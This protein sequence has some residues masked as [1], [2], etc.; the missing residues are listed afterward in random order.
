MQPPIQ[1]GYPFIHN[2]QPWSHCG[3]AF[4]LQAE[5]QEFESRPGQT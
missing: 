5:G 4:A 3:R 2:K 1:T